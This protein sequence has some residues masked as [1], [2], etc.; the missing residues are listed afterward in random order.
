MT[1]GAVSANKK[2][3]IAKRIVLV[4]LVIVVFIIL[5][6]HAKINCQRADFKIR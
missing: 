4:F 1:D 2:T 3:Q 5:Y 6:W